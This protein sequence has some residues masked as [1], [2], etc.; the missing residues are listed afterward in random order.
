[1]N[2]LQS[3]SQ[4]QDLQFCPFEDTLGFGHTRGIT[5]IVIPGAGE[6]NYDSLEVNPYQTKRQRQE[7]EVH[8]LLEKIQPEM[9]TLNPN[10]IGSIDKGIHATLD[11][12]RQHMAKVM[13]L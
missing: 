12:T 11:E 10:V 6:P 1:M 2:H 7:M 4:I 8:S 9:I 5:S 13:I 3:S